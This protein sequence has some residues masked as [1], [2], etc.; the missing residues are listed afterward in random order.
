M[1]KANLKSRFN[2]IDA[3]SKAQSGQT[4]VAPGDALQKKY[5]KIRPETANPAMPITLKNRKITWDNNLK[6]FNR[7]QT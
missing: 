7:M 2:R 6:L 1:A 5:G 4:Q 3:C